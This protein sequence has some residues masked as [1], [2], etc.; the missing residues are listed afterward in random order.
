MNV[1]TL[2]MDGCFP[3][4]KSPTYFQKDTILP[5]LTNMQTG[6]YSFTQ[7]TT[8]TEIHADVCVDAAHNYEYCVPSF[9]D[10]PTSNKEGYRMY[11][12]SFAMHGCTFRIML[13]PC[14]IDDRERRLSIYVQRLF[15]IEGENDIV[16]TYADSKPIALMFMFTCHHPIES[17]RNIVLVSQH[18]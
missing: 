18:C 13:M 17:S 8:C 5:R 11:S 15:A 1:K 2:I 12:S 16:N 10:V 9:I 14:G 7:F 6:E 3:C 4:M